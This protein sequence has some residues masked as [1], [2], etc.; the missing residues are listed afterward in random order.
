MKVFYNKVIS[1]QLVDNFCWVFYPWRQESVYTLKAPSLVLVA[2]KF[3]HIKSHF[4]ACLRKQHWNLLVQQHNFHSLN[5]QPAPDH[6]VSC[7]LSICGLMFHGS[8]KQFLCPPIRAD[9]YHATPKFYYKEQEQ[10]PSFIQHYKFKFRAHLRA[11]SIYVYAFFS[12]SF[13]TGC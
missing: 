9:F 4:V 8:L 5:H 11:H 1:W 3:R 6:A 2:T 7:L 13:Y 10:P 12:G